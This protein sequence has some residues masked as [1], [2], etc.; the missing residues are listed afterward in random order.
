MSA[1]DPN[2]CL[3]CGACCAT[4]RVSFY[5]SEGSS[6]PEGMSQQLTPLLSCMSGTHSRTPRC[7]ALQGRIGGPIQC[8]IYAQRPSPCRE[9]Q[10]GD[11]KCQRARARHGLAP[12]PARDPDAPP[13]TE[14]ADA[15]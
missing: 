5:W 14:L 13:P 2:P 7:V 4:F 11:D 9:L 8:G 6:L 1:A 3:S 12:L 10:T 15:A